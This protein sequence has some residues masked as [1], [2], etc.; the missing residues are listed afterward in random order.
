MINDFQL[1]NNN[2]DV[3][4]NASGSKAAVP[5]ACCKAKTRG[6]ATESPRRPGWAEPC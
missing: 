3:D 5:Y 2:N 1:K 6:T 4:N